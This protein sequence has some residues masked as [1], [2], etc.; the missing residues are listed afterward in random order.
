VLEIGLVASL[1]P[2]RCPTN[3]NMIQPQHFPLAAA[4]VSRFATMPRAPH[5]LSG[6]AIAPNLPPHSDATCRSETRKTY[7]VDRSCMC[8]SLSSVVSSARVVLKISALTV[9]GQNV[10]MCV[11]GMS[12]T[13][14]VF[15]V[16]CLGLFS[17]LLFARR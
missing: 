11:R 3:Q 7:A 2:A 4:R 9:P 17:L 14:H 6:E 15:L 12:C 8:V 1:V 5:P 16:I 13:M 10:A